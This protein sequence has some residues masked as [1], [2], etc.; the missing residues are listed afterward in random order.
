MQRGIAIGIGS[1][2]CAAVQDLPDDPDLFRAF[3]GVIQR[4]RSAD[5]W[6]DGREHQVYR[7]RITSDGEGRDAHDEDPDFVLLHLL[8]LLEDLL[9]KT[10][11]APILL[12]AEL[13]N[14]CDA[15]QALP[16]GVSDGRIGFRIIRSLVDARVLR[17]HH[18]HLLT[19]ITVRF[20][21]VGAAAEIM[22]TLQ[23]SSRFLHIN[24]VPPEQGTSPDDMAFERS[25]WIG[26]ACDFVRLHRFFPKATRL[27]HLQR[28]IMQ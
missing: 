13:S 18:G 8:S 16:H 17:E 26:Q 3:V 7:H 22:R 11:D 14:S 25:L 24:I 19:N 4:S 27:P 12:V 2:G 1:I 9:A 10:P 21:L 28:E 20:P 23:E 6:Q 5:L 15:Q